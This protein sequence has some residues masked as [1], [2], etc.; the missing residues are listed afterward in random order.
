MTP[1]SLTQALLVPAKLTSA[2]LS[3]VF[4]RFANCASGGAAYS[5]VQNMTSASV[6]P[7]SATGQAMRHTDTP[8]ARVTTNSLPAARLPRRVSW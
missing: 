2:I 5:P 8:E 4:S 6:M 7:A 1:P 3:V